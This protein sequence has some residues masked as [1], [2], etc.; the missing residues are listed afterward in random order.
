[1]IGSSCNEKRAPRKPTEMLN[2]KYEH[3]V[4]PMDTPFSRQFYLVNL[5]TAWALRDS[6]VFRYW[7]ES[8][9]IPTYDDGFFFDRVSA[10]SGTTGF[11]YG[12]ADVTEKQYWEATHMHSVSF[13]VH[14]AKVW[15]L[16]MNSCLFMKPIEREVTH[17]FQDRVHEA[18]YD[19]A[20]GIYLHDSAT[21]EKLRIGIEALCDSVKK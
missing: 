18:T 13:K 14:V 2:L 16:Y 21:L 11:I 19:T 6:S 20:Y 9:A 5:D 15:R 10:L 4:N 12:N 17:R 1:M 7:I 3:Q 8:L